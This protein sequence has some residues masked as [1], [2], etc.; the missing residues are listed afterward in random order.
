MSFR[1]LTFRI[2]ANALRPENNILTLIRLCL[3]AAV[4]LTHAVWRTSGQSGTDWFSPWL[5]VPIS[6][7]AVDGFFFL[8]GFLVFRSLGQRSIGSFMVARLGR[9]M[10]GLTMSVL[11][12]VA[13]G[14]WL[15]TEPGFAYLT[16]PT[17]RF[18][19]GNISLTKG[20]YEL[21]GVVC[22]DALC[23]VNGSLWTLPW[24][25]R[26]YVALVL[27]R[28]LR[29]VS[30]R[31]FAVITSLTLAGSMAWNLFPL[32]S[33]LTAH[34]QAGAA[35]YLDQG[36]RLWLMFA[37]GCAAS[38]WYPRLPLNPW[39]ML[40]LICATILTSH[41]PAAF[42]LR[43]MTIGYAILYIG[44]KEWSFRHMVGH[45]PDYSY[46]IYIYAFPVMQLIYYILPGSNAAELAAVNLVCVLP[47]AAL[48]W[49]FVERPVLDLVRKRN[50]SQAAAASKRL[51]R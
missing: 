36:T 18:I 13:V 4:I 2:D 7:V 48:S 32:G 45:W 27:L 38:A 21:T 37:L 3:A 23:N 12:T 17:A 44:F 20:Y 8:S 25:M 29:L 24:E 42:L 14:A 19:L 5:G 15:T 46:G 11:L 9:M 22:G 47:I 31:R 1:N 28:I 6:V 10:P 33:W 50:H 51:A 34:H 49:H 35:F 41:T 26:C 30:P 16:G 43:A 39:A 40:G